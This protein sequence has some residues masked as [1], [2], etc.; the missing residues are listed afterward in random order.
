MRRSQLRPIVV[1]S[2]AWILVLPAG[3]GNPSQNSSPKMIESPKGPVTTAPAVSVPSASKLF[4]DWKDPIGALLI[5]GQQ[6][7]YL[8]PC[9]CTQGQFGGIGRRFDLIRKTEA[10]GLPI[11]KIDLGSL[12]KNPA[13]ARGGMEDSKLRFGIAL[14]ALESMKYDALALSADD[15]RLG[16]VETLSVYLNLKDRPRVVAGNVAPNEAFAAV[17]HSSVIAQAGDLAIGVTSVLAPEAYAEVL[18]ADKDLL[19]VKSPLESVRPILAELEKTSKIQVLLVQGP[20]A[21]ARELAAALPGFDIVVSTSQVDD[22]EDKPTLLNDGKTRLIHVGMKGK[23]V[24]V[25]GF[26]GDDSIRYQR[27]RLDEIRYKN[28]EPMRKLI[29]EELQAQFRMRGIVEDFPRRGN[30]EGAP[31]AR[32][33]GAETCKECH[34]ATYAKWT[35]TGHSHAYESITK[36]GRDRR[37]DAECVTCHTTGFTYTSGWV[38][39]EA[40]PYLKGNQCENCHGPAS[41]HVEA[42][43]DKSF[44]ERMHR[45]AELADKQGLCIRCHDGDNSPKFDFATYY[46]K[47]AHKGM[48][49]Y[50]DPKVHKGIVLPPPVATQSK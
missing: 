13:A 19:T 45:T 20:E 5:S 44:R 34:P 38:S 29:E 31:G 16:V 32:Y 9:G 25:F 42:P 28:A 4:A 6:N 50:R 7:N 37:F 46:G 8:E 15:L 2:L 1:L 26:F 40:T 18:D 49:D 36:P 22:P 39:A 41:K 24:G 47:I 12:I 17:I 35:N 3:C 33:V 43:D 27:V 48:D 10:Q 11:A 14:K 21:L 23:Y 30:S